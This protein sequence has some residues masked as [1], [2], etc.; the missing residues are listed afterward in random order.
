MD[1]RQTKPRHLG[2]CWWH[3]YE[4]RCK[5]CHPILSMELII[6][7]SAWLTI[8]MINSWNSLI[9]IEGQ[10]TVAIL[11][12]RHA[13]SSETSCRNR[14]TLLQNPLTELW[15]CKNGMWQ[16]HVFFLYFHSLVD[17]VVLACYSQSTF[18]DKC[19]QKFI[20]MSHFVKMS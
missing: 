4:N 17:Y 13:Y 12:H 16:R 8:S 15:K 20:K 6:G 2:L 5:E 14:K 18:N 3:N 1:W 10:L 7:L 11:S 19:Q 9:C